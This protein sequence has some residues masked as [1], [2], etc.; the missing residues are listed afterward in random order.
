VKLSGAEKKVR[1]GEKLGR[2]QLFYGVG[3]AGLALL[4]AV[5][6]LW[7]YGVGRFFSP[8]KANSR[9]KRVKLGNL[10]VYSQGVDAR[11]REKYKIFVVKGTNPQEVR[12]LSAVCTHLGCILSWSPASGSFNC[13]CHG[14]RFTEQGEKIAGPATQPLVEYPVEV[15][16]AGEIIIE[17]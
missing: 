2:R 12:I 17:I 14:S 11:W 8:S 1:K 13:P 15:S 9:K 3:A 7:L 6:A 5:G 10:S 4:T 16:D